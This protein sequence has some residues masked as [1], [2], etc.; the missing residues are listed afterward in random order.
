MIWSKNWIQTGVNWQVHWNEIDPNINVSLSMSFVD[1]AW[2]TSKIRRVV[3]E[4]CL[5]ATQQKNTDLYCIIPGQSSAV[6]WMDN[7]TKK[8][9]VQSFWERFFHYCTVTKEEISKWKKWHVDLKHK[10][11]KQPPPFP[12]PSPSFLTNEFP[13]PFQYGLIHSHYLDD[14]ILWILENREKYIGYGLVNTHSCVALVSTSVE[15]DVKWM[16]SHMIH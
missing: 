6:S 16:V 14:L 15:V 3:R 2:F 5:T 11:N 7:T 1:K 12:F 10:I 13:W 9:P 4:P 8:E